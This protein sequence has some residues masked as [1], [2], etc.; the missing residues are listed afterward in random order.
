MRG[1]IPAQF[2]VPFRKSANR[3]HLLLACEPKAIAAM[4]VL[5]VVIAFSVPTLKGLAAALVLFFVS[6][7]GLR[8]MAT[9]D[10][11]LLTVHHESQRY[12]QG[13]WTSKPKRL[14]RWS[15]R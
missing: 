5:C 9:E 10:P 14:H 13:F 7:Y 8:A 4:F 6:R 11:I 1:E 15:H 2:C 12:S 3:P